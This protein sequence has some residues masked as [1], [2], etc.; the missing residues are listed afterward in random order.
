MGAL[1]AASSIGVGAASVGG[2]VFILCTYGV[3]YTGVPLIVF[4][5]IKF[6]EWLQDTNENKVKEYFDRVISE[7]KKNKKEFIEKINIKKEEFI[8]KLKKTNEITSDEIKNL[9]KANYP[10]NFQNFIQEFK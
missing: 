5:V 3:I 8:E 9:N 10:S 4:G 2:V 6:K 7:L 1:F